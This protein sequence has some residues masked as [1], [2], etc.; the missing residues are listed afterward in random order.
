MTD[1]EEMTKGEVQNLSGQNQGHAA[2][3]LLIDLEEITK[4]RVR[5]LSGQ[6]Q[7]VAARELFDMETLDHKDEI[8]TVKFP[9]YLLAVAPS[10]TQ[11]LFAGSFATLGSKHKFR[12]H[13]KIEASELIKEQLV[14]GFQRILAYGAG[15]GLHSGV[16]YFPSQCLFHR[17]QYPCFSHHENRP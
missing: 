15:R 4:G 6:N 7:G 8:I 3:E 11:G 5:N 14:Y 12:K 1:L 10:F 9:E 2:P 16:D 17:D 13:Y